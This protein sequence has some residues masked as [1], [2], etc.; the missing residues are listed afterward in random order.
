MS[1]RNLTSGEISL[2]R[3]L[4]KNSIRYEE[5]KIHNGKWFSKQP[6]NSGMTPSGEIYVSGAYKDDYGVEG[7]ELKG[8]IMHELAHVWQYQNNILHVKTS[9]IL[10]S[11]WHLGNYDE[12]YKYTLE[13]G[14]DLIE[15]GIEQ[16]ASMI[17]DYYLVVKRG[18]QFRVGRIQ[19][20]GSWAEKRDLLK[21]VMGNFISD[22]TYAVR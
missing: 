10:E 19:N 9:A 17:Q 7:P 1:G 6:D 20:E 14:K 8:F 18:L 13:D 4:F 15:Y 11:I 16:Q 12:A 2:A 3:E 5:V 21:R 22:P